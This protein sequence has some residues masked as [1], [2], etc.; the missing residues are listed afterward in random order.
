MRRDCLC[1]R[2]LPFN[3]KSLHVFAAAARYG[4]SQRAAEGLNLSHGAIFQRIKQLEVDLG[5]V[6][7]ERRARGVALTP[8]GETYRDAVDAALSILAT[9][10]AGLHRATNQITFHIGPSFASKWL[11]PRMKSFA[12]MHP[13]IYASLPKF[14]TVC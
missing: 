10:Q 11:M 6:L 4:N 5:V 1:N 7:F 13:Q 8:D 9:A 3:L 12:V 14:T 2:R